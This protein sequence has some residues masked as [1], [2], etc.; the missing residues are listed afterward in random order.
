[1]ST[2]KLAHL[3]N[4]GI[5]RIS[6][7]DTVKLLDGIVT[8]NLAR[9]DDQP[10]IHSGL[11]S[12]QGKIQFDFILVREGDDL[13]L[14]TNQD[15]ITTLI[16]RLTLYRLRADVT[17]ED[18]STSLAV[19]AAWGDPVDA[20]G[21][22]LAFPDPRN[23][24]LGQRLIMPVERI[25]E[26]PGERM[27]ETEYHAHRISIGIPEAELDY[28]LG[29]AFPH[30][31]LYDQLASVDFKKGCYVGQEV[32]SRMQHR[33]TARKRIVPVTASSTL[34]T[35]TDVTAGEATIGTIGSV[36]DGHGLALLRLDRANEAKEKAVPL[37]AANAELTISKPDWMTLDIA[38]GK[39]GDH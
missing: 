29:D 20:P 6:G 13:L 22:V 38:T 24:K 21:G 27:T 34:E 32:V 8:N 31:A 19:M 15:K 28:A 26:I 18:Q 35:G 2:V 3:E 14:E 36:A 9:L 30:E 4:R 16:Q 11:L 1:M 7:A 39:A 33:G 37:T 12:P 10:A 25:A 23:A 5:I 17:F